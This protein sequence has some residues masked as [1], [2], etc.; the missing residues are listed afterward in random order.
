MAWESLSRD[1]KCPTCGKTGLFSYKEGDSPF[2]G[3]QFSDPKI[4]SGFTMTKNTGV[5]HSSQISCEQCKAV[6]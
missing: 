4:T 6:V 3:G 1:L 2:M 5:A